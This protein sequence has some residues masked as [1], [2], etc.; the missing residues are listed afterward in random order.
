MEERKDGKSRGT[1][2]ERRGEER[3][4]EGTRVWRRDSILSCPYELGTRTWRKRKG[5]LR[6]KVRASGL[7]SSR[8][9]KCSRTRIFS[10]DA[11][12]HTYKHKLNDKHTTLSY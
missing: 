4:K 10:S 9:D 12:T 6:I 8:K 3:V 7:E 11:H 2:G 5:N 1:V